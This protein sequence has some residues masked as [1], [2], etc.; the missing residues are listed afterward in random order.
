MALKNGKDCLYDTLGKRNVPV[1]FGRAP[2]A[3]RGGLDLGHMVEI[4]RE[5]NDELARIVF[6]G[7]PYHGLYP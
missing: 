6:G 1:L 3:S 4:T 7:N 5:G 2:L